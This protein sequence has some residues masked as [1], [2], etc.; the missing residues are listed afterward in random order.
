MQ[1]ADHDEP[2]LRSRRD[3]CQLLEKVD[4]ATVSSGAFEELS[5]FVDEEQD[6]VMRARGCLL[7]QSLK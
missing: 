6:T 4:I 5:E 1:D 2:S 3:L 7:C